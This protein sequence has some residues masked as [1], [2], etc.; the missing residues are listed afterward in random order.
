MPKDY[1]ETTQTAERP[2]N[3]TG[4]E[5]DRIRE[6]VNRQRAATER[7]L[8]Q[9]GQASADLVSDMH[10]VLEQSAERAVDAQ[11][12]VLEGVARQ[13]DVLN[14]SLRLQIQNYTRGWE[15]VSNWYRTSTETFTD[16]Q[17]M[18]LQAAE[19]HGDRMKNSR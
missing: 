19:R 13:Q 2:Q 16:W 11:R 7:V 10:R 8:D 9:A 3:K 18:L 17:N 5:E 12:I 15:W 6:A 14:R 1:N 4:N